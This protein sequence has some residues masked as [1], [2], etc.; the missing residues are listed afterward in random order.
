MKKIIGIILIVLFI[1]AFWTGLSLVLYH[2]GV[3]LLWSIVVPCLGCVATALLIGFAELV[4][5]LLT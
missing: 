2:G 4:A 5:W 3:G 1:I